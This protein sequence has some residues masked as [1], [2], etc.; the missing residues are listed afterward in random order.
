MNR[1]PKLGMCILRQRM[2]KVITLMTVNCKEYFEEHKL[3]FYN[4]YR[5]TY[6]S[7]D[8]NE[9]SIDEPN[10]EETVVAPPVVPLNK[11][12]H[13]IDELLTNEQSYIQTL[14]RAID[15][16]ISVYDADFENAQLPVG[17]LGQKY[18]LFGNIERIRDF[19]ADTF[20]P[21]LQRCD[22]TDVGGICE[23]FCR[24]CT[25]HSFYMYVLYAINSKRGDQI[26]TQHREF[27]AQRQLEYGDRLGLNS[28]LL[29]P[30]QRLPRY[31][32]LLRELIRE[33]AKR[34]DVTGVKEQIASCCRAEK[35]L[36]RLLDQVNSSMTINDIVD[37]SEVNVLQLGKFRFLNEF[38]VYECDS[39]RRY[40]GKLFLFDRGVL[41]T[42]QLDKETLQYRGFFT[43]A[44]LGLHELDQNSFALFDQRR[45]VRQV[46]L[47]TEVNAAQLWMS[48]LA[49]VVQNR[50]RISQQRQAA[51]RTSVCGA[52]SAE[53]RDSG[54]SDDAMSLRSHGG[55]FVVVR[56]P[57]NTGNTSSVSNA[58]SSGVSAQSEHS[59]GS[60]EYNRLPLSLMVFTE[61]FMLSSTDDSDSKRT[62]WYTNVDSNLV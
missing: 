44:R 56:N 53:F 39:R 60:C 30:I 40:R 12:P 61:Q 13:I 24:F 1:P 34:L 49:E 48:S 46:E 21:S 5:I 47:A 9:S 15:V 35:H 36:Q 26:A 19:H 4:Q 62:T 14:T 18:H 51:T 10:T 2:Q 52:G 29:Q 22:P 57:G 8:D 42:E 20:F 55:D 38:E 54:I 23:T 59:S 33:L 28:F 31:Q 3:T 25:E 43:R 45:N 16:Y 27:F 6:S 37:N 32:L 50:E 17:L 7:D 41:V 58:W 11:V